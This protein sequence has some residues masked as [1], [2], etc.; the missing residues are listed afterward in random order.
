[1]PKD[2]ARIVT[3][4]L[5]FFLLASQII[6]LPIN[7]VAST[8]LYDPLPIVGL[9]PLGFSAL[10]SL[11]LVVFPRYVLADRAQSLA[12]TPSSAATA[13]AIDLFCST[14]LVIVLV[15]IWQYTFKHLLW[16]SS[17]MTLVVYTAV[18]ML[19][20]LLAH[21]LLAV[22]ML[23]CAPRVCLQAFT[24]LWTA[25]DSIEDHSAASPRKQH[26][27]LR[28]VDLATMIEDWKHNCDCERAGTCPEKT[29]LVQGVHSE[30]E[31]KAKAI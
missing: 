7:F 14:A 25:S 23:Y 28:S 6:A 3:H 9:L 8:A 16:N 19:F 22:L 31:G 29:L 27:R 18:P 26:S 21:A 15:L 2:T 24:F 11:L 12:A 10:S 17:T 4:P 30:D 20:S 1:M 13:F 5:R